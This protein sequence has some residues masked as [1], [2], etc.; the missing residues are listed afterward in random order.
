[1]ESTGLPGRVQVSRS[2]Y[3]RV[4]DLFEFEERYDIEVKGKGKMTTY[5][6]KEP[7]EDNTI[8]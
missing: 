5:L 6:L 8:N 4:H 3:E 2:T 7:A 1:M